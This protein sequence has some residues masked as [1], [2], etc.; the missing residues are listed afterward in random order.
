MV[1]RGAT[2]TRRVGRSRDGAAM[3]GAAAGALDDSEPAAPKKANGLCATRELVRAQA[4]A[5][6]DLMSHGNCVLRR[7]V[8]AVRHQAVVSGPSSRWNSVA[9]D[10]PNGFSNV[11]PG[12][13][14]RNHDSLLVP[15][16][17]SS[18][19][20]RPTERRHDAVVG[21]AQ[22]DAVK[23]P[24]RSSVS[25]QRNWS[26]A[27]PWRNRL[28]SRECSNSRGHARTRASIRLTS[29][30]G[31]LAGLRHATT[32]GCVSPTTTIP[33]SHSKARLVHPRRLPSTCWSI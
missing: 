13:E 18:L 11:H 31:S 5:R 29:S 15:W 30:D 10:A 19:I 3:E 2:R 33:R 20:P 27:A 21:R 32:L 6:S 14:C 9:P 17:R 28:R 7:K 23:Q 26:L 16:S 25:A 24:S 12:N 4:F 22:G 1:R 8:L